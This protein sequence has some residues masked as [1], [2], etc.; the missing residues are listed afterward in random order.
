MSNSCW[1]EILKVFYLKGGEKFLLGLPFCSQVGTFPLKVSD[2]PLGGSFA[3]IISLGPIWRGVRNVSFLCCFFSL[4]LAHERWVIAELFW[5]LNKVFFVPIYYYF[6]SSFLFSLEKQFP[7]KL[8]KLLIYFLLVS[9]MR[10]LPYPKFFSNSWF[11]PMIYFF[12]SSLWGFFFSLEN[13]RYSE[14][15]SGKP[16]PFLWFLPQGRLPF[17]NWGVLLGIWHKTF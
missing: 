14:T 15:I 6:Y 11:L 3:S 2:S 16:S 9:F 8:L 13:M 4:I 17:F 5:V 12:T 1:I 7:Y 10:S